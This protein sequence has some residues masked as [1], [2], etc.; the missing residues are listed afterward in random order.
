MKMCVN[1]YCFATT[2]IISEISNVLLKHS[3]ALSMR[4][5]P[6]YYLA[7]FE[8]FGAAQPPFVSV[9]S[10]MFFLS[11]IILSLNFS[12]LSILGQCHNFC[13]FNIHCFIM[14]KTY[15]LSLVLVALY[16]LL[17]RQHFEYFTSFNADFVPSWIIP[18]DPQESNLMTGQQLR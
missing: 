2:T 11:F 16:R 14:N 13:T 7:S 8:Y 1:G 4:T 12:P 10:T 17:L 18:F 9:Q 6:H 5:S 15:I 3:L